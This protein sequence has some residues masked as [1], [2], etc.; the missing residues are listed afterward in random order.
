MNLK[1]P[2]P[3][4]HERPFGSGS[5]HLMILYVINW[6]RCNITSSAIMSLAKMMKLAELIFLLSM[7]KASLQLF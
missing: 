6:L 4:S 3:K 1:E 2:D 7:V 5:F